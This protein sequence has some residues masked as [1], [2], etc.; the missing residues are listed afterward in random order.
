MRETHPRLH[1]TLQMRNTF[2]QMF[3]KKLLNMILGSELIKYTVLHESVSV[4]S[5]QSFGTVPPF[6]L[7]LGV[8]PKT[9]LSSSSYS[10]TKKLYLY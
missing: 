1:L 5:V 7:L 3:Q 6:P 10:K 8:V 9:Q 4:R 2:S